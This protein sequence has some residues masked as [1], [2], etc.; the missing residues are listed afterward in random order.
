MAI[1]SL[2]LHLSP[3]QTLEPE[4]C[5]A[6]IPRPKRPRGWLK[7]EEGRPHERDWPPFP[8]ASSRWSEDAWLRQIPVVVLVTIPETLNSVLPNISVGSRY[9]T[10]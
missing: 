2:N 6:F 7:R 9:T 3:L 5:A 10:P 8:L 1:S 4:G